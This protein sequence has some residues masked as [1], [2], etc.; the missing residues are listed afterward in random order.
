MEMFSA[1]F[2]QVAILMILVALGVILAKT[3]VISDIGIKNIT[4]I[5]LLV[6]TPCVIIKSFIREF[7]VET[8]KQ[9]GLSFLIAFVIHVIFIILS[10]IFVHDKNIVSKKV[11][12]F[13]VIFCNAGFMGLPLQQAILGDEGVFICSA[14]ITTFNLIIWTYGV[15][16]ATGGGKALTAKKI[17]LNPAVIALLIGVV[18]FIFSIPIPNVLKQP[19]EYMV[20]LNTPLPM[21]IIGYQLANSNVLKYFKNLK[22]LFAA[23]LRLIIFPVIALGVL[24]LFGLR[25][26]MLVSFAISACAPTGAL[27]TMF[28]TKYN[29]DIELSVAMVS[30][31]TIL[32]VVTMPIIITLA[33]L[34]A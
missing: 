18:I 22:Y 6:V 14:Y 2:L 9:L 30:L 11:L 3:K 17:V 1:V 25:G 5:V 8:L 31:T 12:Q 34:I 32:S 20:S 13:A 33:Q 23:A 26:T 21:I 16:L 4:E 29:T 15:F 10:L 7:D 19:I 24:Y 28:A 27:C